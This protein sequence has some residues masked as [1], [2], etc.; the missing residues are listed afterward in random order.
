MRTSTRNVALLAVALAFPLGAGC[1]G[2]P[3]IGDPG[4]GGDNAMTSTGFFQGNAGGGSFGSDGSFSSGPFLQ[5]GVWF[6]KYGDEED[7]RASAVAVNFAGEV[8]L[9][10]TAKGIINF[11]NIPWEGTKTD[12]DVVVA[13][14]S[15]EGQSMWSRRYGDSCDQHSG[16][17]AHLPSGSVLLA[18]DFCGAMDFG[19]TSLQT[20]GAEVDLF[21]AVIDTLG[22]DVY[23]RSFGGK[24]AQIARAA[25]VDPQGNAVI[26]GSFAEAFDDGSGEAPSAGL[27]DAFVA[28]MDGAGKP[29]WG[30]TIRGDENQ[31][32]TGV[33]FALNEDVAISGTS[34]E[35]I[36]LSQQ[37]LTFPVTHPFTGLVPSM[38][39]AIR[40]SEPGEGLAGWVLEGNDAMESIGIGFE[41][42]F[43]IILAGSF[44]KTLG[45][46]SGPID[47]VGGWDVFLTR[48]L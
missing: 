28:V 26:V 34:D 15:V 32:G 1:A 5:P 40:F 43:G 19:T 45:F 21:V 31:R 11:G 3:I 39:F 36:D 33:S 27:D 47:S 24:G 35:M 25:V 13:K 38:V 10:G 46:Q 44:Q 17:V 8:A 22:E 2:D 29:L 7:Q 6:K 30:R 41:Q 9:V 23:S 20:K 12:T 42:S 16:A 18:G 37:F 4:I 48:E 14:L